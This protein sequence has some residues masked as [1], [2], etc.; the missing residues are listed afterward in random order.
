MSEN[1]RVTRAVGIVGAATFLSRIFGY[2]RDM[3]VAGFFGTG[4]LTDAFIAAFRIPNL[5]RRLFGEGSLGISFVP[6][7]TEHIN[8]HGRKEA[9][10]LA[11]S[12]VR[13]LSMVLAAAAVLGVIFAPWITR[14]IA[15]GFTDSPEKFSLTVTLTRMMFP[16]IFFIG[17]VALFMG[18][19][20]VLGHFAAPALAPVLLNVAMIGSV[21]LVSRFSNDPTV[22][23]YALAVG[24]LAGGVLQFVLQV[25]FLIKQGFNFWHKT[26]LLHPGLR[27]VGRM[28]MPATFGAAVFQINTLV[29]NLLASFQIDGSISYLYFADR[30]VQFPLGVF[31]IATATAVLPSLSRQAAAEDYTALI[32]T[33]SYAMRLVFFITVPAMVGLIVL[34]ESIVALLFQ[35]GAFSAEATQLTA[36]ALLY[37]ATGLWAFAA[38]RI[39]VNAFYAMQDART[40]VKIALVSITANFILGVILM[41]PMGHC[42]LAL[43]LSLAMMLNLVLLTGSLRSRLGALGGKKIAASACKT[44]LCSAIMGV[45]VWRISH[46]L[47]PPQPMAAGALAGG[48]LAAIITGLIVYGVLAYFFRAP[49]LR[50]MSDISRNLRRDK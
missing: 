45:V 15:Y 5:L 2:I 35:R 49:E 21:L 12:A 18:I 13:L 29:I 6:V 34:R 22:R 37:Y 28:F 33:L 14:A 9:Y 3:V 46:I 16:Y 47:I 1:S 40:P 38:V 39:V 41:G 24:V 32:D 27:K 31:G 36:S 43:A 50:I 11:A 44:A 23:I 25:P 20:N 8:L 26:V 19:L 48:L 30:L 42:G 17:M 10:E 4:P 7:F